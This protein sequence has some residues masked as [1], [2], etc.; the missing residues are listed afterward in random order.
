MS[1]PP[2][3]SRHHSYDREVI[4]APARSTA[5]HQEVPSRAAHSSDFVQSTSKG[6]RDALMATSRRVCGVVSQGIGV[7]MDQGSCPR[8]RTEIQPSALFCPRC[9][10]ALTVE[11]LTTMDQP[12][13]T[14]TF[15][16]GLPHVRRATP[17]PVSPAFISGVVAVPALLL[18]VLSFVL[19]FWL[20][21][22]MLIV[23]AL[24]AGWVVMSTSWQDVQDQWQD[25]EDQIAQSTES[26]GARLSAWVRIA[27][28]SILSWSEAG[29]VGLSAG[30]RRFRFRRQHDRLLR[31]LGEAVY[32]GDESSTDALKH[33]A[34]LTGSRIDECREEVQVARLRASER[35]RVERGAL[36]PT[37]AF[38]VGDL[39][40]MSS[41]IGED[42][43]SVP[44]RTPDARGA[45]K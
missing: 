1:R 37:Q 5:A 27:R 15:P 22:I 39:E 2:A 44:S 24:V 14:A 12:A 10:D 6:T 25:V 33:S 28:V 20:V 16:N 41:D 43:Q 34:A 13:R 17:R 26:A 19:G 40:T 36:E 21:G 3:G 7:H 23:V 9:G 32:V 38:S 31:S 42:Q 45:G 8:C 18:A 4:G 29:T 11:P 35:V 30:L